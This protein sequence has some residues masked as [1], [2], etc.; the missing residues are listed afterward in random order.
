MDEIR[1]KYEAMQSE[2]DH[3]GHDHSGHDH[4]AHQH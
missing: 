3:E 2:H 1:A 4:T